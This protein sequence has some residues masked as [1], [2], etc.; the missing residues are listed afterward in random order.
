M[1]N[2]SKALIMAAEIL[3]GVLII[4][5]AVYLIMTMGEYSANTTSRLEDAQI[6]QFNQQ[7][8]QYYGTTA[9][10]G[11]EP[12]P[13]ECTIHEIVGVANLVQKINTQY[14]F[15]EVEEISDDSY[16]IQI[17]LKIGK[18]NTQY[19]MCE[20]IGYAEHTR[21]VNYMKFVEI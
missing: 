16:Y 9:T 13:I 4:S 11:E 18:A 6:T 8:L 12:H 14:G 17:D 2:A 21:L 19:F 5:I 20:E 3:V 1:E 10:Q 15:E 7:F